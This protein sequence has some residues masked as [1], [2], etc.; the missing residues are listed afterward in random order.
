M[1]SFSVFERAT[2][3]QSDKCLMEFMHVTINLVLMSQVF[4]KFTNITHLESIQKLPIE[5]NDV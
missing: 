1:L 5:V 4:L 2:Q 3:Q